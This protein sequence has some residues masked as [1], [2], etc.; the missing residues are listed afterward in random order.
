MSTPLSRHWKSIGTIQSMLLMATIVLARPAEAQVTETFSFTNVNRAIPDGNP[1]GMAEFRTLTS[2]I[3]DIGS[4]TVKLHIQGNFNGDLYG[5]LSHGS[6]FSVLLNRPGR[7]AANPLGYDDS[8]FD[9]TLEDGAASDIHLYRLAVTPGPGTPLTGAWQPDARAV[10]PAVVE[11]TSAR[12][13]FLGEFAGLDVNGEWVLFLL[14][15]ESG[16]TNVLVSWELEITGLASPALTW[17]TPAD[18][19]YG[20]ALG[21]S[22]LNASA[23]V[24]GTFDYSPPAGTVLNAGSNQTLSVTFTPADTNSYVAASTTVDLN[25]LPAPLTITAEDKSKIYGETVPVLT[26]DYNGFVNG[27]TKADLDSDVELGT[28]AFEFSPV[29]TYAITATNASDPNYSITMVDGTLT[30]NQALTDGL[31]AVSDN[32]AVPGDPLVLLMSLNVVA[33]GAG[34]PTG[35]VQFTTNGV[36]L[37][38]PVALSAGVASLTNSTLPVGTYTVSAAYAGDGNFVGTTNTLP[39]TL[40]LNTPPVAG[41]DS[42]ERYPLAGV[43][44]EVATLLTNDTDAD[45]DLL[46]LDSVDAVSVA[47]G[48]ISQSN[49]WIHYTPPVG[50]TNADSFNYTIVDG[51]G[52]SAVGTVSVNIKDDQGLTDNVSIEDLGGGSYR[53]Q[54]VGVPGRQYVIQY[55]DGLEPP[56]W[57]D[58][59]TVT[60]DDQGRGETID[61][62]PGGGLTRFYRTSRVVSP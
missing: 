51:R 46:T 31:V 20:T 34:T 29:G 41:A 23:G 50:Y 39:V 42:I 47:G 17:A 25:V 11:D 4:V 30:V 8:G 45:G 7:T 52:G 26:A 61:T 28:A 37:G 18:I 49:G 24:P 9:V 13:R 15:E 14:D 6:G 59:T 32:P 3:V 44:V 62:P 12:N 48:T 21:G 22:E 35:T 2:S 10:D 53:V 36:P 16:G 56:S 54:F 38:A 5:Y 58:L 1:G 33:P 19:I 57:T 43:K 60:A 40:V 27:D 55:S